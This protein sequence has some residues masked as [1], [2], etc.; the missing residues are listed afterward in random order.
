MINDYDLVVYKV[1]S[2]TNGDIYRSI[3]AYYYPV[4]PPLVD[5]KN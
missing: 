3:L 4:A 2:I 1:F 5:S